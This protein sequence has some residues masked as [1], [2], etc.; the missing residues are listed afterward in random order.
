[1]DSK[2]TSRILCAQL[3]SCGFPQ[4]RRFFE[5]HLRGHPA[6]HIPLT[7]LAWARLH[8][9]A[10]SNY[11]LAWTKMTKDA[12]GPFLWN[13]VNVMQFF[14]IKSIDSI[15]ICRC[16]CPNKPIRRSNDTAYVCWE[17]NPF[18]PH[19]ISSDILFLA[20]CPFCKQPRAKTY[21]RFISIKTPS[22]ETSNIFDIHWTSIPTTNN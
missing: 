13:L 21:L 7:I 9:A 15:T 20:S 12:R 5:C 4:R 8:T 17:G 22:L 11:I 18:Q 14:S 2:I 19:S 10:S 3:G 16:A 6:A 1:M